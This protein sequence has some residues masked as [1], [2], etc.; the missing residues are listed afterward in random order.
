[1]EYHMYAL[2]PHVKF[3]FFSWE[4]KKPHIVSEI[5]ITI[6]D[7]ILKV[8]YII[9]TIIIMKLLGFSSLFLTRKPDT[10]PHTNHEHTIISSTL[11]ITM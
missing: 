2:L 8:M 10:T 7:S 9:I 5:A 3:D 6:I 4:R 11:L 1:M